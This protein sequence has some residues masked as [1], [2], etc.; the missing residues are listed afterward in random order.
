MFQSMPKNQIIFVNE[1]SGR[2]YIGKFCTIQHTQTL[3]NPCDKRSAFH[4]SNQTKVFKPLANHK[5]NRRK[6]DSVHHG[7]KN[8]KFIYTNNPNI[9][10]RKDVIATHLCIRRK[11]KFRISL[12]RAPPE[13]SVLVMNSGKLSLWNPIKAWLASTVQHWWKPNRVLKSFQVKEN[14]WWKK[15]NTTPSFISTKW[16]EVKPVTATTAAKAAE[17]IEEISQRFGVP[18]RIITDLSTS[19]TEFE[20]WD[21]CQESC[22]PTRKHWQKKSNP[23]FCKLEQSQLPYLSFRAVC[24]WSHGCGWRLCFSTCCRFDFR[25]SLGWRGGNCRAPVL[26]VP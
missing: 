17:F 24:R 13:D 8:T 16:I 20:F 7:I 2:L 21:Y 11:V 12:Q 15:R 22:S 26:V 10:P 3:S 4:G 23:H 9:L 5:F 18:N 14:S 1:K 19:F 25:G 6:L